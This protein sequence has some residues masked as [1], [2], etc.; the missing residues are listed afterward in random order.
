[1]IERSSPLISVIVPCFNPGKWV[2]RCLESVFAQTVIGIQVIVVNDGS[3]DNSL[4]ILQDYRGRI[5]FLTQPNQGPAAARNRGLAAARGD[6]V[7]FLDADD[8]WSPTM[9]AECLAVLEREKD[10][11]AV[12]VGQ[13]HKTWGHGDRI[14]PE[15]LS[16]LGSEQAPPVIEDF[17]DFWAR[18]NHVCT[19]SVVIRKSTVDRAGDQRSDLRSSEDL[20]YWG[21]LATFGKW[22]FVPKL[23]FVSDGSR[24]AATQGWWAKHQKR[25]N[26]CPTVE[27]W[28]GRIAPRLREKEWPG[29][30][31]VRGRVAASYAHAKMLGGDSLGA[32]KI[33]RK[34][35]R[36]F[37]PSWNGRGMCAAAHFGVLG[38][39]L[40]C[41]LLQL[42]ELG[43]TQLMRLTAPAPGSK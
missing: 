39:N 8:Y 11:I 30:R 34:Y 15:F 38:W 42:R 2:R 13:V 29:F 40:Y 12:S 41:A 7:A 31:I 3:T 4:D 33:V 36:E 43:K 6:Y 23:L 19:G 32:L 14:C 26:Q 5:I 10:C 22:A 18:H 35:G 37:P 21:Y 16:Q 1:M 28:Q 24:A 27:A 9:L 20:E 17:F 25:W